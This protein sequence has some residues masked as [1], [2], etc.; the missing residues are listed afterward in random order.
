MSFD[1][2]LFRCS[3]SSL[4][5]TGAN[6]AVEDSVTTKTALRKIYKEL[7]YSRKQEFES[8]HMTKGLAGEENAITVLSRYKKKHFKKNEERI[9][10]DFL[11]GE[12]DLYLGKSIQQADEGFDTKCSWSLWTFPEADEKLD[13]KY[14]WQNM[15]YMMLTGAKKWT[16]AYCL[17]NAPEGL[18]TAEKQKVWYAMGCPDDS[19][20]K[21]IERCISIEK[22]MIFDMP[23]FLIDNRAFNLDCKDWVYDIPLSERVMLFETE[24]D[25]KAIEALQ[26]RINQCRAYMNA[27]F[28]SLTITEPTI[29]F[30]QAA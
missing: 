15:C 2:L 16:T 8:K 20:A 5:M 21:Y 11:T 25:E 28:K 6:K 22:N 18:I 30:K 10:N 12:P 9:N 19:N 1:N 3:S 7:K 23:Q 4:L 17:V 14:Y 13:V 29:Y 27:N 24:R 26:V